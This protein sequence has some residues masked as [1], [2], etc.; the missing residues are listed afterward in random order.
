[1]PFTLLCDTDKKVAKAYDV[2]KEKNMYGKIVMGIERSTFI[3][4]ADGTVSK[5]F[6]KVKADGHAEQVLAVFGAE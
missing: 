1:M 5:E 6:H 2:W 4:G 3:I